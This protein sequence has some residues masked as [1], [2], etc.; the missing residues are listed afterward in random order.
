M[1]G[2]RGSGRSVEAVRH[3]D[4]DDDDEIKS[5][6][7][8]LNLKVIFLVYNKT[9]DVNLFRELLNLSQGNNLIYY[10]GE[11]TAWIELTLS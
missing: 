4:D 7:Q 6:D 10:Q 2:E 8:K 11:A 9:L 3:D 5:F 1:G